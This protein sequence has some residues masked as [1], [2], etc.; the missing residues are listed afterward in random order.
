MIEEKLENSLDKVIE[1][2]RNEIEQRKWYGF[3]DFG[4][5]MHSYDPVR[6]QWCYDLGGYAWQNTELAPNLWLWFSF[7]RKPSE[8]IF[9]VA[10]AMTRHTSEVD[11]YHLGQYQGF[12]SRHNVTHWG[13][14]M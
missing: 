7:M 1:F 8:E 12:G 4:D 13:L 6:H 10:E 5:F 2:Y 11:Q 3:W 9:T 14:W